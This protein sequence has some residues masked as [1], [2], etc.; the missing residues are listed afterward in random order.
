ME[1]Q[2][3]TLCIWVKFYLILLKLK[4]NIFIINI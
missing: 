3:F 4:K 2:V 1:K